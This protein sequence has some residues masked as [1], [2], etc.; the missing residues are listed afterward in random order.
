MLDAIEI[1]YPKA[2]ENGVP[3]QLME[4]LR[5]RAQQPLVSKL[6][7]RLEALNEL[8]DE[9]LRGTIKIGAAGH[10]FLAAFLR[11]SNLQELLLRELPQLA[12]LDKF[13]QVGPRKSLRLQPR[14]VVCH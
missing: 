12:A 9:L 5:T 1:T 11:D 7:E 10:A 8:S 13:A 6:H 14:G 4:S 3:L 2:G